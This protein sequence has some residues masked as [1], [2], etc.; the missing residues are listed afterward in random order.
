MPGLE[1]HRRVALVLINYTSFA[2]QSGRVQGGL[3]ML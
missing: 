3:T 2:A 1:G